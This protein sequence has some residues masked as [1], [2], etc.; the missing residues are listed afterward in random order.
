MRRPALA[1]ATLLPATLLALPALAHHGE[2]GMT[3]ASFSSGLISGLAHP[4]IGLDHLAFLLAVGLA[5][6]IAGLGLVVPLAFVGAS[7]LGVAV[8]LMEL[9]V[10]AVEA[11]VAVSVVLAGGLLASGRALPAAVWTVLAGAAGIL[12]G[13]AY[14]EA[15]IGAE[16]TPLLAYLAG[17]GIVQVAMTLAVALLARGW[18]DAPALAPRLAGATILGIGI[19]T[20]AAG[21]LPGG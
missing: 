10:P 12:H 15:I 16:P 8:H 14:G 17:L 9:P 5:T 20:L 21:T 18:R 11:L 6:G 13:Y 2:G 3:P 7:L 1:L 19:A 4:V